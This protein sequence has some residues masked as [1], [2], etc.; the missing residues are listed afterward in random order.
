MKAKE[1]NNTYPTCQPVYL[2][3]DD[4]SLT[5]T[6]TRSKAWELGCGTPVV[7]VDGKTGGYLLERIK[8]R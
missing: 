1:W 2:T 7:S 5:A 4:G 6:Q 3:E 8:A